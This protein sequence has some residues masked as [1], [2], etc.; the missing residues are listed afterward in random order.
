MIPI[1]SA[2]QNLVV[3]AVVG[4]SQAHGLRLSVALAHDFFLP[5]NARLALSVYELTS[6]GYVHIVGV[7]SV[8]VFESIL[9]H[10]KNIQFLFTSFISRVTGLYLGER[11]CSSSSSSVCHFFDHL[12]NLIHILVSAEEDSGGFVDQ[13]EFDVV[14]LV[15][16]L[17][18]FLGGYEG[19]DVLCDLSGR[20]EPEVEIVDA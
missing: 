15:A 18:D 1:H 5:L 16:Y 2:D 14:F 20:E 17:G 3:I 13:R 9:E 19:V 7:D 6:R 10:H 8:S 4:E 11:Y 12:D